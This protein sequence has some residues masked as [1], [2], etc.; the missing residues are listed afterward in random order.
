MSESDASDSSRCLKSASAEQA[1]LGLSYYSPTPKQSSFSI[2]GISL[3]S[4]SSLVV[5]G[6]LD[7]HL[8]GSDLMLDLLSHY[9]R[10]HLSPLEK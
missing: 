1:K 5:N 8:L 6:I 9:L 3:S 2:H 4:F 10:I 7:F